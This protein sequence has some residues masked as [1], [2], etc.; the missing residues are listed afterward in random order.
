[1]IPLLTVTLITSGSLGQQIQ[2]ALEQIAPGGVEV[3]V[4]V[5]PEIINTVLSLPCHIL[6]AEAGVILRKDNFEGGIDS[7]RFDDAV[8]LIHSDSHIHSPYVVTKAKLI[9]AG[10]MLFS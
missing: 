7:N 5:A 6:G 10:S 8:S 2:N 3:A 1:M 9:S 4:V